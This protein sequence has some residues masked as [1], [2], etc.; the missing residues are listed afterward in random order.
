MLNAWILL[1]FHTFTYDATTE[2]ALTGII[3]QKTPKDANAADAA[4]STPPHSTL[5][6]GRPGPV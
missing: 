5:H 2:R 4:R 6:Y 1:P 3:R